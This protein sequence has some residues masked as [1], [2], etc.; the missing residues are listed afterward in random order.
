MT[1]PQIE[2]AYAPF[3]AALRA[4]GSAEPD[5]G[6]NASQIGAHIC[7]NNELLSEL[8]GRMHGGADV[9]YDN[10]PAIDDDSLLAYASGLGGLPALADAVQAS[11]ARLALAYEQL[12]AE[13]RERPGSATIA[14]GGPHVR[15]RPGPRG[16]PIIG[17]KIGRA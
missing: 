8:A 7:L 14:E 11:A 5:D 2:A 15:L 12:T 1:A 13:E 9:S 16:D 17:H 6:W 10:H 4:G 3:A